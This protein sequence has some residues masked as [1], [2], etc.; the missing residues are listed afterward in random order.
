MEKPQQLPSGKWRQRYTAPDGRRL[1]AT[2]TSPRKA[3]AKAQKE[4]SRLIHNADRVQAGGELTKFDR[5]AEDWLF[6]RRPGEPGGYAPTSYRKRQHHLRTL[7]ATFG[8]LNV[9]DVKPAQVRAWWTSNSHRPCARYSMYWFLHAI[10]DVALDDE[11]I[12]RNPCRVKGAS[13]DPSKKRPTFTDADMQRVHD[14]AA[15]PQTRAILLI[16]MGTGLRAGE[17]VAL[18]WENVGLFDSRLAILRHWTPQGIAE[19][20]KTGANDT[21]TIALAPWVREVIEDLHPVGREGEGPVFRNREGRR[22]SLDSLERRFRNV[23][24]LAG[25]PE[26]HLH[27]LRHVALTA[28]ARQPGV[29]LIDV[30]AHGGHKSAKVAMKYQHT[31]EERA[32]TL[33]AKIEAPRWVR[34]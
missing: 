17:L 33:A 11:L 18:D 5:F 15:D 10:F 28:Y 13:I 26:M 16:L 25:L 6:T 2:D 1:S 23:R 24:D 14:N 8:H 7:N 3:Q 34:S 27:D 12:H 31:D 20:T 32:Q 4:L 22:L 9:Q 30:M 29:T 19:G 21:R